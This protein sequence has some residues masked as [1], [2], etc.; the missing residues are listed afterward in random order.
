MQTGQ[1]HYRYGRVGT[2]HVTNLSRA[3]MHEIFSGE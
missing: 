1:I 3:E 2:T